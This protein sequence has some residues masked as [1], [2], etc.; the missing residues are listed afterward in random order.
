MTEYGSDQLAAIESS[1]SLIS[2]PP[3]SPAELHDGDLVIAV[4]ATAIEWTDT[5]MITGQY[6]S[7]LILQD[8]S[9]TLSFD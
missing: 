3:P 2:Q 5:I 8:L 7:S 6:V 9:Q 4:R 1:L